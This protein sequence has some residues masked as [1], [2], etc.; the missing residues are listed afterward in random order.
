MI[1][2]SDLSIDEFDAYLIDCVDIVE[3]KERK[4][5]VKKLHY[6]FI[7]ERFLGGYDV[8]TTDNPDGIGRTALNRIGL[9]NLKS[10]RDLAYKFIN[11]RES[12]LNAQIIERV[13]PTQSGCNRIYRKEYKP[14]PNFN[15]KVGFESKFFLFYCACCKNR[16]DAVYFMR[17]LCKAFGRTY[18]RPFILQTMQAVGNLKKACEVNLAMQS[19][20]I[21]LFNSPKLPDIGPFKIPAKKQC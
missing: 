9:E 4:P 5:R 3:E 16:K 6:V 10:A 18:N 7:E 21:Q 17:A 19:I 2:F 1:K 11:D 12:P 14:A 20:L 13:S 15:N 8:Y